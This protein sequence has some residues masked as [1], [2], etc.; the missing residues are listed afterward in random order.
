MYN[1]TRTKA[2]D[3]KLGQDTSNQQTN[4]FQDERDKPCDTLHAKLT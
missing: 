4:K 3:H 1:F 2:E